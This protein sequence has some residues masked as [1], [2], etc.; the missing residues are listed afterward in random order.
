MYLGQF[1]NY[2]LWIKYL[3]NFLR[4]KKSIISL[5]DD[6]IKCSS[7]IMFLNACNVMEAIVVAHS[8][9][10]SWIATKNKINEYAKKKRT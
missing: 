7:K 10:I 6:A 4:F 2:Q 5:A 3:D 8:L 1:S 9:V